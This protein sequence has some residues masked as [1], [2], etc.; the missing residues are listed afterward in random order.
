M[1]LENDYLKQ[2]LILA[3][4]RR[5]FCAPN[6]PVGA[7]VVNKNHQIIG[8]GEHWA[9][10][11]PHA[12]VMAL[13]NVSSESVKDAVLYITLEPCC[14]MGRTP[15]CTDLI[16]KSGIKKVIYGFSDPNPLVNKQGE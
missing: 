9:A 4:K 16:I 10:G 1:M 5:G 7:I 8:A 6:P 12:E 2:A 14:H 11:Y 13:K 15:P 3:S